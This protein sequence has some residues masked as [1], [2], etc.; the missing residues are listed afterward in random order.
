ME[1]NIMKTGPQR[2]RKELKPE[3]LISK[4]IN[5]LNDIYIT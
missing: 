1:K 5:S 3:E 4:E 2:D